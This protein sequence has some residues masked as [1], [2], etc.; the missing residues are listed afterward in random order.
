MLL[1]V[2]GESYRRLCATAATVSWVALIFRQICFWAAS[3]V[4]AGSRVRP[5]YLKVAG[6]LKGNVGGG[7]GSGKR[8]VTWNEVGCREAF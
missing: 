8:V 1:S 4:R 6:S 5:K 7:L 2:V 3:I